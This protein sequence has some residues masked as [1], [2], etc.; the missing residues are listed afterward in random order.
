[1]KED[2]K[3]IEDDMWDKLTNGDIVSSGFTL[4]EDLNIKLIEFNYEEQSIN[5]LGHTIDETYESW[6]AFLNELARLKKLEKEN[7]FLRQR[8]NKLQMI[9]QMFKSGS[10]DLG[11]LAGLVEEK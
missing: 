8:E 3:L 4:S 1:M 6:E 2:L 7:E 9:E 5:I 11:D 10:V